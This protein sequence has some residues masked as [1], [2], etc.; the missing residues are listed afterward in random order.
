MSTISFVALQ[1]Y[2]CSTMQ[3][4][5]KKKSS[6]KWNCVVCNEKQSVR[7]VFY[8]AILAKDVRLF[9]QDFNMS[10]Q[11]D[12][13]NNK[14][15]LIEAAI[16]NYD[17]Q[18]SQNN[19]N[20][21]LAKRRNDWSEYLEPEIES[22][23]QDGQEKGCELEPEFV[24]ELP[25]EIFK[26]PKLKNHSLGLRRSGAV[27]S[28]NPVSSSE[29]TGI[30]ISTKGSTRLRSN[31]VTYKDIFEKNVIKPKMTFQT[32][33][34]NLRSNEATYNEIF[35]KNINK[36]EMTYQAESIKGTSKWAEYLT[37]EDEDND[38]LFKGR[39]E[40][41]TEN[42]FQNRRENLFEMQFNDQKVEE[43]LHPDFL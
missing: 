13:Q 19:G 39:D 26:R 38:Y 42:P 1:C 7:K 17:N 28:S 24:T 41:S 34:T 32:E 4:K 37:E 25:K 20:G 30:P 6:N 43:D 21:C 14:Q 8:E 33:T 23:S 9:V 40:T 10:R 22:N 31:E 11:F 15:T 27:K 35:E 29:K 18:S 2:E 16:G 12:D 5:Q 36:P 3:V